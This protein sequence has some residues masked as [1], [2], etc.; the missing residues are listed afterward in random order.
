M[1]EETK[2]TLPAKYDNEA[3]STPSTSIPTPTPTTMVT[4]SVTPIS[5]VET[6]TTDRDTN[7][8]QTITLPF[9]APSLILPDL[10][11]LS[12]NHSA[13]KSH[14]VSTHMWALRHMEIFFLIG[15]DLA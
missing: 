1:M 4:T 14:E 7:A 11:W 12:S 5:T 9:L 2:R 8:T 15:V 10:L 6:C 3:A 13:V